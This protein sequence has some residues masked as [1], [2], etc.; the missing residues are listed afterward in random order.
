M[1]AGPPREHRSVSP[2]NRHRLAVRDRD[3]AVGFRG[4][5][6]HDTT[7]AAAGLRQRNSIGRRAGKNVC[8]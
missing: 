7:T 4:K 2:T 1:T 6:E 3:V 5:F 8:E